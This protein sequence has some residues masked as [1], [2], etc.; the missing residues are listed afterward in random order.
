M[1]VEQRFLRYFDLL[2]GK[3]GWPR[4]WLKIFLIIRPQWFGNTRTADVTR[5]WTISGETVHFVHFWFESLV[6]LNSESIVA[7]N[8][9]WTV[10]D[11][12]TT[13][14]STTGGAT[15]LSGTWAATETTR[16]STRWTFV[17]VVLTFATLVSAS[18]VIVTVF[19]IYASSITWLAA[20]NVTC[21]TAKT[22]FP[23]CSAK[24]IIP[25]QAGASNI[26]TLGIWKKSFLKSS[27]YLNGRSIMDLGGLTV[28]GDLRTNR[29]KRYLQRFRWHKQQRQIRRLIS[30]LKYKDRDSDSEFL[31]FHRCRILISKTAKSQIIHT[32][33]QKQCD[34][35]Y[36]ECDP[37]KKV[38]TRF[39]RTFVFRNGLVLS[40]SSK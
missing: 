7:L 23:T 28:P 16:I 30:F 15:A 33:S 12:I 18:F 31:E 2:F 10:S 22:S 3:H 27:E 20:S 35:F 34:I 26:S 17:S 6:N 25:I 36:N 8:S 37:S 24:I 9:A 32:V 40:T 21:T 11:Q 13:S 14:R 4:R 38:K 29:M 5:T 39:F 1:L 19:L